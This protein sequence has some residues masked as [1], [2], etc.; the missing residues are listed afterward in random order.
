VIPQSGTGEKG[1]HAIVVV[2]YKKTCCSGLCAT[3]F[4]TIDS[5]GTYWA[6]QS[7]GNDWVTERELLKAV[8]NNSKITTFEKTEQKP[9]SNNSTGIPAK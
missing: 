7:K 5:L 4:Q 8:G 2:N 1:P 6:P 9:S 3:Q